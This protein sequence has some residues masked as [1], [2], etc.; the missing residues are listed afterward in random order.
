M[1]VFKCIYRGPDGFPVKGSPSEKV[2]AETFEE[3]ARTFA[4]KYPTDHP[5][6]SIQWGV[7]G[8]EV[9]KNPRPLSQMQEEMGKQEHRKRLLRLYEKTSAMTGTGS[10]LVDLSY[11]DINDL[12]EHMWDFPGIREELD[13]EERAI[14]ESLYKMAFFDRNLQAGLQTMILNQIASGQSTTGAAGP[15][16]SNL[17]Q[18]AALLGG[19]AALQKLN[20]IEE[21]TGDVSEW[22]G[23]D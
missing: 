4:S 9:L 3:A 6:I 13:S 21:N 8:S 16:T 5:T 18:N 17:A 7:L 22:F 1:K 10:S 12:I 19:A 11:D 23:F 15:A 14:G 2:E 20:Q